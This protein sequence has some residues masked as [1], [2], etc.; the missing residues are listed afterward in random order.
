M[1]S[2]QS[3]FIKIAFFQI[4]EIDEIFHGTATLPNQ[5]KPLSYVLDVDGA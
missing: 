1:K 3:N 5:A 2:V 4:L